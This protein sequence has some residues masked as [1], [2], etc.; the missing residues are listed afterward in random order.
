MSPTSLWSVAL[1][2]HTTAC[3]SDHLTLSNH[4]Y[5][6]F[7][8]PSG[9]PTLSDC[10]STIYNSPSD[11]PSLPGCL[12]DKPPSPSDHLS[13]SNHLY[14][15]PI[16]LSACLS[17]SDCLT[18]TM[19]HP[20]ICPSSHTIHCTPDS[21]QSLAVMNGEQSRKAKKFRRAFT[22]SDL[23]LGALHVSSIY[24]S[25]SRCVAPPNSGEDANI[26]HGRCDLGATT[27]NKPRLGFS[28]M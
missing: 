6:I 24:L 23:P 13:L 11:C 20:P 14:E 5:T 18:T 7:H 28:Y 22:N 3:P 1:S 19:T 21:S 10:P 27:L 15:D 2:I 4:L 25:D 12:Y 9:C 8:H 26:T 17:P 16:C